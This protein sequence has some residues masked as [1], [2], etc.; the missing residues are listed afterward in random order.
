LD[1]KRA[2]SVFCAEQSAST[3]Q[4][5][6]TTMTLLLSFLR[7]ESA[8]ATIVYGLIATGIALTVVNVAQ[9]LDIDL[10]GTFSKMATSLRR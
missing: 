1:V 5:E 8:A 4:M 9:A 10:N 7:S 3:V 6:L 2:F